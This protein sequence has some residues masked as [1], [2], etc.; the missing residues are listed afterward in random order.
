[1]TNIKEN[2]GLVRKIVTGVVTLVTLG[3]AIYGGINYLE[4]L[5]DMDKSEVR[6]E[7]IPRGYESWN[8]SKK[9]IKDSTKYQKKELK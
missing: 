9:E 7:N 1:M 8:V 4:N 2:S 5:K 3:T 6:Y